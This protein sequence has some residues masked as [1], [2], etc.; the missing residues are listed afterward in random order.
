[1]AKTR[2]AGTH[3]KC[4]LNEVWFCPGVWQW[5]LYWMY[6]DIECAHPDLASRG[7]WLCIFLCHPSVA[8]AAWRQLSLSLDPWPYRCHAW[9]LL[10]VMDLKQ[11][12]PAS[13]PTLPALTWR[14]DRQHLGQSYLGRDGELG[15]WI[16]IGGNKKGENKKATYLTEKTI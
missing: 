3:I 7:R 10:Q 5:V 9:A 1:M 2:Y 14:R 12:I 11:P 6:L 13:C 4:G 8:P 16:G 15:M